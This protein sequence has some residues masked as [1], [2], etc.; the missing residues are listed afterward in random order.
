MRKGLSQREKKDVNIQN[1]EGIENEIISFKCCV[2]GDMRMPKQLVSDCKR[3]FS[4]IKNRIEILKIENE[5]EKFIQDSA[6][7]LFDK[8]T[9]LLSRM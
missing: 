9:I 5:T 7:E 4:E 1:I 3:K 8:L 6:K 2:S